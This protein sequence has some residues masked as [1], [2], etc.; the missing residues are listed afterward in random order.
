[1]GDN[2]LR[3][4]SVEFEDWGASRI[5]GNFGGDPRT[6]IYGADSVALNEIVDAIRRGPESS[7]KRWTAAIRGWK[8]SS[9]RVGARVGL[10][11]SSTS[12]S[13]L[14]FMAPTRSRF[15]KLSTRFVGGVT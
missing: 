9:S 5:G 12:T 10:A 7:K 15:A 2:I 8:A 1:M 6:F 14:S 11:A 4:E 3:L 13:E